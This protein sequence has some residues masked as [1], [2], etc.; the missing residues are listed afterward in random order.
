MK[1]LDIL[2]KVGGVALQVAMPGG[3]GALVL[4]AVN[5]L[6][7]ANKQL[8][9]TAT[10][11]EVDQVIRSL[12][13]SEQAELFNKEFDVQIV[14]LQESNSTLRE[15]LLRD[16]QNPH[17]TRPHIALGSF[18][19]VAFTVVCATSIF[20]YGVCSKDPKMVDAI[21][22]GWPFILSAG[23]P[24]VLL[25]RSYFGVLRSES[26]QKLESTL[27]VVSPAARSGLSGILAEFGIGK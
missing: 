6:M 10:A 4:K 17:S 3:Q 11:T 13:A 9:A 2:K 20:F 19:V 25:L 21:V 12:P 5:A 27:G 22:A 14:Q 26:K 8:G 23:A 16:A 7:P 15:M 1:L 18:Y 24:L